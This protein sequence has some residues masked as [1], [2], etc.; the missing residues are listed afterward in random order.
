MSN[1]DDQLTKLKIDKDRKRTGRSGRARKWIVALV[2]LAAVAT[3]VLYTTRYAPVTV[4]TAK[5]DVEAI[6]EGK[7]AAALTGSGY[8]VPCQKIEVSSMLIGRVTEVRIHRGDSVKA[9]DVLIKLEDSEYQAHVRSADAAVAALKAQLAELKAGSR[10]QEI[11]AAKAAV[12]ASEATLKNAS[13]ELGRLQKLDR[14][15][16]VAKQELDRARTAHEVARARLDADR[17]NAEVVG[18][19][20]RKEQIQACQARLEQAE[21]ELKYAKTMLDYTE[22]RAPIDGVILEKLA[23]QGELVTNTNFGGTRGAKSSV[24][25]MAD[26]AC[27]KIEIDLNESDVSKVH[28]DQRCDV[29]L[30]SRPGKSYEGVVD[31]ISPQA[32]RQKGTVQ[33]KVKLVDPD[34]SIKTEVNARVTFL[35]PLAKQESGA[36]ARMWIPKKALVNGSTVYTYAEG[37]AHE[38]TVQTGGE[39]DRGIEITAGLDGTEVLILEPSERVK[40][41]ARLRVAQ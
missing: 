13:L 37:F 32:D 10:P 24:V 12:T 22:I 26:L 36:K 39:S 41:G 33:A 35:M 38:K 6:I 14:E 2:L 28:L 34:A 18:I 29:Q 11:D 23:E 31:E 16:A 20:P 17:K 19:G 3:G 15:G 21:A 27:L 8:V 40:A 7:G 9:G 30:D 25:T 4:K 1:L 5:V